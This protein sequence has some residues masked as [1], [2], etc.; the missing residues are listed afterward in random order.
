MSNAFDQ[1]LAAYN[2]ASPGMRAVIDSDEIGNF[3]VTLLEGSAD[4]NIK[5]TLIISLS[6]R[7]LGISNDDQLLQFLTTSGLKSDFIIN[8]WEKIKLFLNKMSA[9]ANS[10]DPLAAEI[11]ETETTI[12]Q[13]SSGSAS[14]EEP[15]YTST[16]A[17][18]LGETR[19]PA[20]IPAPPRSANPLQPR[21]D[22]D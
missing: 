19:T 9:Q 5:R 11:L 3:A 15:I 6:H 21:W 17:A 14:G 1:F 4:G 2:Q 10:Y 7:L 18:I 13:L 8:N 12:N 16:Q 22:T 20:P